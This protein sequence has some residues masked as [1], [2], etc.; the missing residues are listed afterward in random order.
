MGKTLY[1]T[2][3]AG[4][5]GDMTVAA[6]LDL[7]ADEEGLRKVL[8]GLSVD[9][10]SV[11]TKRVKKSAID[12]M[13][14]SVVLDHAHENHDH[15]MEYLHGHDHHHDHDHDHHHE[16]DHHHDHEHN[17]HHDHHHSHRG[18]AEIQTIISASSLSDRAK[19]LAVRIFDI[20]AEAESHAHGVPKEEVHFHEVGAV[21]SIVDILSVAYCID[22][23]DIDKVYIP[24]LSEGEGTVRS[25]HGILQIPVPAV[26]DIV[27][28]HKIPLEMMHVQGEFVTPTGAAIA[29]ALRTTEELPKQFVI[30]KTGRGAGK[31]TY[32]R[33]S[34]LT[35]MLITPAEKK[36]GRIA[37]LETNVDDCTGEALGFLMEELFTYGARD[38]HYIPCFMKKNR[39]GYLVR[40]ICDEERIPRM[41]EL[42]FLHTTTIGIRRCMMDRTTLDRDAGVMMTPYGEVVT[43]EVTVDGRKRAYKEYE[44]VA[45]LV[46]SGNAGFWEVSQATEETE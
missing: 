41:E 21:D 20:L 7:G 43:K 5:S 10:F 28:T 36:G 42:I 45:D 11:E 37:V 4:I 33:P 29:A 39:P 24:A 1:L 40:V 8:N 13:D 44:S 18:L 34:I 3:P 26:L 17:H 30:E 16:H 46:R 27:S 22:D 35:A 23:L 2:C 14:F 6:L 9:G 15:D 38:V 19:A 32:E 31:R 25:Q 12:C